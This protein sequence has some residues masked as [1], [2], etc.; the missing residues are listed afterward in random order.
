ML[1]DDGGLE[2]RPKRP[3]MERLRDVQRTLSAHDIDLEEMR[4]E[5]KAAWSSHDRRENQS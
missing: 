4:R 3:A 5:S 1:G 2:I